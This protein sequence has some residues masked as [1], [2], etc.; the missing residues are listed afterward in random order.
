MR[1]IPAVAARQFGLFTRPQA[2]EAGWTLSALEH[3]V[4]TGRLDRPRPGVFAAAGPSLAT[5]EA[6]RRSHLR[7]GAAAALT[8]R[9]SALSHAAGLIAMG[10]PTMTIPERPCLT[11]PSGS[12]G[13]I[14]GVHVHRA[15]L[16]ATQAGAIGLVRSVSPARAVVDT[17]R[18][19]GPPD[20]VVSADAALRRGLATP[21]ELACV[22][23]T[24]GNWPGGCDARRAV[25][26]ADPLS[27]SPLES[28][29][30]LRITE[31]GLPTPRLQ[32][33][34]IDPAGREIARSDFYWDEW[35]LVG[36]A[37]GRGKYAG[38]DVLYAEKRREDRLRDLGLLV[39]RW[40]WQDVMDLRRFEALLREAM[41]R[42]ARASRDRQWRT[43]SSRL[44][45]VFT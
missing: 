13:R 6:W 7:V 31:L 36:E 38:P 25:A 26:L 30:R 14:E 16:P 20:G 9:D 23:E 45:R 29:S 21:R 10:L 18:E 33:E 8:V 3:G 32:V 44:P 19:H 35:G 12:T 4:R 11:L 28:L 42:A 43:R 27:E 24:C 41:A 22:L 17:A 40:G 15:A 5:H 37:D 39:V 34:I 2:L 1:E